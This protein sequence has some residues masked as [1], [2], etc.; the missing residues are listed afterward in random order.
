MKMYSVKVT[1]YI[2]E[3]WKEYAIQGVQEPGVDLIDN[4]ATDGKRCR[5]VHPSGDIDIINFGNPNI[6]N[7]SI[8]IKEI[9]Q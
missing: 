4:Y 7:I 2:G 6:T 9:D 5:L 3:L 1:V 8:K